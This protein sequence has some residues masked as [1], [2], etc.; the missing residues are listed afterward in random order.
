MTE[1]DKSSTNPTLTWVTGPSMQLRGGNEDFVIYHIPNGFKFVDYRYKVKKSTGGASHTV[2]YVAANSKTE[3]D[4][5]FNKEKR[6]EHGGRVEVNL[7]VVE[8]V[9]AKVEAKLTKLKIEEKKKGHAAKHSHRALCLHGTTT[10]GSFFGGKGELEVLIEVCLERDGEPQRP[11]G[12]MMLGGIVVVV[13]AWI[14][15]Y[16]K[17]VWYE[18]RFGQFVRFVGK[19]VGEAFGGVKYLLLEE[20]SDHTVDGNQVKGKHFPLQ[21]LRV[22]KELVIVI[23][24]V[25]IIYFVV[26]LAK[27]S[28]Q[29]KKLIDEVGRKIN[30]KVGGVDENAAKKTS[31]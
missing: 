23:A 24:V 16:N 27:E 10:K 1:N 29:V 17:S 9:A 5:A 8:I 31:K 14:G 2:K 7:P 13:L 6:T 19:S 18:K 26:P 20:I 4:Q 25:A 12:H 15:L 30:K 3:I 28:P 11:V 21:S 22:I